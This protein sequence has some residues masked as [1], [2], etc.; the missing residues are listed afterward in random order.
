[1]S[2]IEFTHS[3][4]IPKF[5]K[6]SIH[7]S[8]EIQ[9]WWDDENKIVASSQQLLY[10][11]LRRRIPRGCLP[12]PIIQLCYDLITLNCMWISSNQ[13]IHSMEYNGLHRWITRLITFNQQETVS[14]IINQS[15]TRLVTSTINVSIKTFS[16]CPMGGSYRICSNTKA[17]SVFSSWNFAPIINYGYFRQRTCVFAILQQVHKVSYDS[18]AIAYKIRSIS[19]RTAEG[20]YP[21]TNH[22]YN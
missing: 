1:M 10:W 4:C 18:F 17:I 7:N 13:R 6:T 21:N 8:V 12:W 9:S 14:S 3:F 15:L 22:G 19:Q 5:A 16:T 11:L 2:D 20:R